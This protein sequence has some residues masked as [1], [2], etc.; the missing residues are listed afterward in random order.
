MFIILSDCNGHKEDD[1]N[2]GNRED[3]SRMDGDNV[4]NIERADEE[5][6]VLIP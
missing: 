4:K 6:G 1:K 5:W 3:E 2:D